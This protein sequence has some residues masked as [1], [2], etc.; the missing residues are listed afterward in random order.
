MTWKVGYIYEPDLIN[1]HYGLDH[2]M[3]PMKVVLTHDLIKGYNLDEK[4]DCYVI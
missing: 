2:P 3:K 1:I 4:M